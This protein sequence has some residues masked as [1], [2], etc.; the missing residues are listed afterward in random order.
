MKKTFAQ[1]SFY[2]VLSS[3]LIFSQVTGIFQ[4]PW[5][6][7]LSMIYLTTLKFSSCLH[8]VQMERETEN[9]YSFLFYEEGILREIF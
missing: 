8:E 2:V 9:Q 5:F 6:V 7:H 1:L 3:V 4:F